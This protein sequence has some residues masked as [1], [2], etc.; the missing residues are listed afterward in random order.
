MS[1]FSSSVY[2]CSL[3]FRLGF[4]TTCV[5]K[6]P[7]KQMVR[8]FSSFYLAISREV[9]RWGSCWGRSW[10]FLDIRLIRVRN[11]VSWFTLISFLFFFHLNVTWCVFLKLILLS[12]VTIF[13]KQFIQG[14]FHYL[15]L[16][17]D[18]LHLFLLATQATVSSTQLNLCRL[19]F[20]N[21]SPNV[22]NC[23]ALFT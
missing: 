11:E 3:S 21:R 23:C 19:T 4:S 2:M 20:I 14:K 12:S 18:T 8:T 5:N 15:F 6:T 13:L 22:S 10:P 1:R 16:W 9:W 7:M 17:N